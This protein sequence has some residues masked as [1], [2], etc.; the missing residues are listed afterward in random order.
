MIFNGSNAQLVLRAL[1][2][3]LSKAYDGAFDTAQPD[4]DAVATLVPSNSKTNDYAWMQK[5]PRMREWLGEKTLNKLSGHTYSLTNKDFEAT[6]EVDRNDIEDDNLGIYAPMAQ[7]AGESA[8]LWPDD[9]VFGCLTRGFVEKCYDGL[10]FYHAAHVLIDSKGKKRLDSNLLTKKLSIAS[11]ADAQAS[12]GAART[13][14]RGRKDE[15][16]RPLK[17]MPT[18]LVVPPAL[19][20]VANT[21]MTVDRL[22]DG[23]PNLYKGAAKVLVCAWLETETEWH[24]LDT[25]RVIKPIVFQQRKKPTFVQQT[26]QSSDAVFMQKKFRF[27]A[28]SRGAAGYGLW[29]M[30]VGSTGTDL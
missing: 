22:E 21:L 7:S 19:E 1:F 18:L 23:K 20:D 15:E 24:V 14:L 8:K 9:L 30:A 25:S 4:W 28:E 27:G 26:D 10:S 11:L 5:F 2:S 6:V 29:Q 16:G 12:F 17:L 3:N 13:L